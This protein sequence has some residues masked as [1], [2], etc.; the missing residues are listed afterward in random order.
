MNDLIQ[1]QDSL[2]FSIGPVGAG[3]IFLI[4]GIIAVLL[5]VLVLTFRVG[6]KKR[7]AMPTLEFPNWDCKNVLESL[8]SVY[9]VTFAQGESAIDWY[10]SAIRSKRLGSIILR[11]CAIA[12]ASIGALLPLV[13]AVATK[14]GQRA[15]SNELVD[16][17]WGY[18]AFATAAACVA[19]DKFFGLSTG[20]I[21]YMK[22][23]LILEGAITNL[24]Y[25]W[26]ALLARVSN[27]SPTSDEIQTMLQKLKEFVTF[28]RTQIQLETDAWILEFQANLVDLS[29]TVKSRAEV[30]KP[31]SLQVTVPNAKEF[32]GGARA[33]LDHSDERT[34]EGTQC[35]FTSVPPG[36]HEILVRGKK[37]GKPFEIASVVRVTPDSL[38][39]INLTLPDS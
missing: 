17:Q 16:A 37:G 9:A 15:P 3:S 22:T 30:T 8:R 2:G 34:I 18:I 13:S 11:S 6:L 29:N 21:R 19:A 27:G 1:V 14:F 31:G 12:L 5:I 7:T 33:L 4:G 28:V 32:D 24:R 39:S 23:Q 36:S 20:W 25:D 10:R 26:I 38:V 35:L